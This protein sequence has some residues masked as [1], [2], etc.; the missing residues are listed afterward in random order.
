[1]IL[2]GENINLMAPTVGE[3]LR[4]RA[5]NVIQDIARTETAAGMDYI[6]ANT[7]PARREGAAMMQWLVD[8][9]QAAT[10]LPLALD[11]TSLE[12]ME[13]GLKA[14]R[15]PRPAL[16]NS[17]SLARLEEE[18][19]LMTCFPA[20]MVGLLWGPEGMPRDVNERCLFAVDLVYRANQ[21][22]V[23]SERIWLD[24]IMTPISVPGDQ[25]RACLEFMSMVPEIAPGCKTII[26]LSNVSSGTPRPLRPYLNRT[27]LIMM[28]RHGLY[29]AIVDAYDTT[30]RQIARGEL[31]EIT[32]LVHRVMD[33]EDMDTATL[34]AEMQKYVKTARVL[35]GQAVYS[36]AWLEA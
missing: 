35:L 25:I 30:L 4:N 18:L 12:S 13:A 31:P 1:M 19:P 6:N 11:T 23:T 16:I 24:P 36:H 7:G 34:P 27:F 26:G 29:A 14:Y 2:V 10:P 28:Q 15:N 5:S 17:I 33:G 22:G 9:I 3:A 32:S 21:A 8:T 20:E